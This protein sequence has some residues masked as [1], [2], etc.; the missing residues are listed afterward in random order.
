[1]N[2]MLRLEKEN[3]KL[4]ETAFGICVTPVLTRP[5]HYSYMQPYF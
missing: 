1:M 2:N 5:A 3:E 4:N